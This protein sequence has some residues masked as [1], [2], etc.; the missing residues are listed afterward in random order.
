MTYREITVL[1]RLIS[2][3]NNKYFY[4]EIYIQIVKII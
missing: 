4:L 3:L 2:R 1:D